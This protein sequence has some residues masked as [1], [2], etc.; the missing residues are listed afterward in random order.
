MPIKTDRRDAEGIARL[1]QMGWFRPVHCKAV[2]SQE[3]R[4]LL[5][6]RKSVKDAIVNMELSLRGVLRNFGLRLGL[7]SK[8]RREARVRELIA[9][10]A[11]LEAAAEPILRAR[12]ALRREQAGLECQRR[13]DYA[14]SRRRKNVPLARR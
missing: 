12:A 2:S 9:G 14:P 6:S 4:A 5:T 10:N 7:V 1:L 11:M 3:K 13:R 8:G